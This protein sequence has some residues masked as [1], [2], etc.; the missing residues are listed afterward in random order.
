MV[1]S[2]PAP[3]LAKT[4]AQ[5]WADFTSPHELEGIGTQTQYPTRTLARTPMPGPT[6]S[7]DWE[8]RVPQRLKQNLVREASAL[9]GDVSGRGSPS[10]VC[11]SALTVCPLGFREKWPPR[12]GSMAQGWD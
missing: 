10:V 3:T 6:P 5:G 11:A 7:D 9:T 12:K 1:A 8:P 2:S 4:R